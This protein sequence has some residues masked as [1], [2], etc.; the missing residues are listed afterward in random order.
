MFDYKLFAMESLQLFIDFDKTM[1]YN[2]YYIK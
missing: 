1:I 2:T